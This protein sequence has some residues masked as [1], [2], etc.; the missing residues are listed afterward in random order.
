[1]NAPCNT[2]TS[3]QQ[4]QPPS[5]RKQHKLPIKYLQCPCTPFCW[6]QP[7]YSTVQNSPTSSSRTDYIGGEAPSHAM[8]HI[9]LCP[10]S[11]NSSCPQ[12]LQPQPP[13]WWFILLFQVQWI[14]HSHHII[15]MHSPGSFVQFPFF[16][17]S[18]FWFVPPHGHAPL[19]SPSLMSPNCS[20]SVCLL[21]TF[22]PHQWQEHWASW[23]SFN[24]LREIQ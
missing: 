7:I 10:F 8:H 24:L 11:H 16:F 17:F 19:Q 3:Q 6:Q 21:H 14:H 1:M 12:S 18:V 20:S 22:S 4:I 5:C 2:S 15:M 23:G 13:N 9:L